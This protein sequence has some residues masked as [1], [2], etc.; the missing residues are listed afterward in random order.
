LRSSC[1]RTLSIR[2][3]ATM[4]LLQYQTALMVWLTKMHLN[5]L[6]L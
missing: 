2:L 4:N 6:K 3:I 1:D 5:H